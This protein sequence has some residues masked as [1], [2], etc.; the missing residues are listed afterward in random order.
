MLTY[1][2]YLSGAKVSTIKDITYFYRQRYEP[3]NSLSITQKM[4]I[5]VLKDK[6]LA[7][8]DV[9]EFI[10]Q[11]GYFNSKFDP[12]NNENGITF[13]PR[14]L[15][16]IL[17]E[18]SRCYRQNLVSSESLKSVFCSFRKLCLLLPEDYVN[19][20]QKKERK[21]YKFIINFDLARAVKEITSLY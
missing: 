8:A 4:D 18:L 2:W 6:L 9:A 14:A 12:I 20:F 7:Y 11:K 13:L 16:F 19:N 15:S 21:A 17:P 10:I 3:S 5:D 1:K